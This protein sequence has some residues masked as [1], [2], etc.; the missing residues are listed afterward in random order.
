MKLADKIVMAVV[1]KIN[2][3][4]IRPGPVEAERECYDIAQ[5]LHDFKP[6]LRALVKDILHV[7]KVEPGP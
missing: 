6:E 7:A 1:D 3:D 5:E 4:I 2:A